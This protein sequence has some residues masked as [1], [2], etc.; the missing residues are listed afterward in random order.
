MLGLSRTAVSGGALLER[1]DEAVVE[2]SDDELTHDTSELCYHR[3][4]AC[5][6]ALLQRGRW[7]LPMANQVV[8]HTWMVRRIAAEK[9]LP[10]EPL[11][12]NDETIDAMRAARRGELVTAGKP[13]DLLASLNKDC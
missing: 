6:A 11:V 9:A 1:L 4:I 12:P 10:F 3:M 7:H 2:T 8:R 5:G 13:G